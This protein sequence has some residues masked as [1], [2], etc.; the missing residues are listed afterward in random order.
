MFKVILKEKNGKQ[1]Y[2]GIFQ[3]MKDVKLLTNKPNRKEWK[4]IQ[5]DSCFEVVYGKEE[6]EVIVREV[7]TK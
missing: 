4:A 6:I 7:F 3:S 1:R 5:K 2:I